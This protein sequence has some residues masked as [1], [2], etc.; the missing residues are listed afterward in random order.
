MTDTTR[1]GGRHL[2]AALSTMR[3]FR[4]HA[5]GELPRLE[6]VA[7]PV[8]GPDEVLVATSASVVSHLDV[9]VAS[10]EFPVRPDL[11]YIPG[12]EGAGRVV[13]WGDE[14]RDAAVPVGGITRLYGSGLGTRRPGC[15]AEF[16]TVPARSLRPVPE[17]LSPAA[18]AAIGS[19]G[20]TAWSALFLVG[21][22]DPATRLGVTGATGAVG[23]LTVGFALAAGAAAPVAFVR[24]MRQAGSFPAT[25]E[26]LPLDRGRDAPASGPLD[27]LVDTIGGGALADRI[28]W[29]R[30]GGTLVLVGYTAGT[31][32]AIDLPALLSSDVRILPVN[33]MRRSQ[34]SRAIEAE[35][36]AQAASGQVTIATETV[37]PGDMAAGLARLAQGQVEGR[38]VVAW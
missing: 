3:A 7:T 22:F 23:S 2:V 16:V 20:L 35:I 19:S 10:G 36:L 4:I 17:G 24:T 25:V 15:W 14:V 13:A 18:G 26:V 27:L 6:E 8:P 5:W 34:G 1:D 9:T 33:M 11:P 28:G 31:Q 32:V 29:I 38:L 37:S 30:P 12:V 21:E